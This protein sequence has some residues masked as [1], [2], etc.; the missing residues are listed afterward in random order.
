[1]RVMFDTNIL[2]SAVISYG[3]RLAELT[4]KIADDFNIVLSS[5]IIEELQ[6]AVEMKFPHKKY[7]FD[8]FMSKLSFEM[9]FTP[10]EIYP[11]IYPKIRDKKDYPI[12]ASAILADV[13]VFITGDKD[14]SA[15]YIERPEVMTIAEFASKYL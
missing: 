12:L 6:M 1:M 2:I 13:D 4:Q 3:T 9:V 11:D 10:T 14:F 8:R 7:A 5:Q 15:V